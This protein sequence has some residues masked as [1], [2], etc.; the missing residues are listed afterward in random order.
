ME[1]AQEHV[2]QKWRLYERAGYQGKEHH[3]T[4]DV[5]PNAGTSAA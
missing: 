5:H 2:N 3:G 4:A 1:L